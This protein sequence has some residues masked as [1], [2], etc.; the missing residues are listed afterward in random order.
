MSKEKII[1][2]QAREAL[3]G[4]LSVLIAGGIAIC[5]A[6][7]LL[8]TIMDLIA[9]M[10]GIVDVGTNKITDGNEIYYFMINSAMLIPAALISPIINGFFKAAANTAIHK[11]CE[12]KDLFYFFAN[13]LLY[14]KTLVINMA[15]FMIWLVISAPFEAYKYMG[16]EEGSVLAIL[17]TVMVILW[18]VII[19]L[20]FVHYPLAAYAID[21]SKGIGKYIF[22]YIGFSFRNSG[23]LLMLLFSMFGWIAL[24]FFVLPMLYVVPYLAVAAMNSAR[25]LFELEK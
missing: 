4:N 7:I 20:F 2:K 22:G 15:L 23:A 13:P 9:V 5:A 11:R 10:L 17:A 16:L 8:E 3:K 1:K 14:F 12:A 6:Y 18:K 19:Y 24:C 25:W 21:D